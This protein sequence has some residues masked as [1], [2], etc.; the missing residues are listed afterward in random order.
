VATVPT[1]AL[2]EDNAEDVFPNKE[3]NPGA[4]QNS[5]EKGIDNSLDTVIVKYSPAEVDILTKLEQMTMLLFPPDNA[6]VLY[7]KGQR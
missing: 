7:V 3:G 6:K 4:I 5:P 1:V 2:Q